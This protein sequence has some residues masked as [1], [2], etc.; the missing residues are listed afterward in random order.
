MWFGTM[1]H[2][3]WI[4]PP[5]AGADMSPQG[6]N[7]EGTLLSGGGYSF[8]SPDSHR[9]YIFE[10]SGA[11]SREAAETMQRYRDGVYSLSPRDLVYFHDPLTYSR[12]VLPK[13]WAHPGVLGVNDFEGNSPLGRVKPVSTPPELLG[14]GLPLRGARVTS[15]TLTEFNNLTEPR[16]GAV[17]VPLPEGMTLNIRA[18]TGQDSG[19]NGL[20]LRTRTFSNSWNFAQKVG[21]A[22]LQVSGVRGFLLGTVGSFELF[23][24]RAYIGAPD[25]PAWLPGSGH[26]GCAFVGN[27]TWAA[28]SG[29]NGG[30]VG[31]AATLR[32]VGDWQ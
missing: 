23:G 19:N 13:R 28:N 26:S 4:S 12:N 14:L 27:P 3:E 29:V 31:Y 18:W 21:Q 20:Y 1:H 30:Q 25:S 24:A 7:T 8:N 9:Q 15:R 10:W 22:P 11:S 5:L 6:W 32:E 16:A 2:S 17:W